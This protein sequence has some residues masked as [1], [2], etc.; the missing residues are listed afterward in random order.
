MSC[1][2]D[3]QTRRAITPERQ[4][5][6]AST[7]ASRRGDDAERQL[8]CSLKAQ[9]TDAVSDFLAIDE[10][11]RRFC[12]P[13]DSATFILRRSRA[14]AEPAEC[15]NVVHACAD[16][17]YVPE[18]LACYLLATCINNCPGPALPRRVRRSPRGRGGGRQH[19]LR[20]RLRAVP[21]R[22]AALRL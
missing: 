2:G 14:L 13:T 21:E 1:L 5:A 6:R 20:L 9:G 8:G 17:E 19:L 11:A 15:Q 12:D 7:A 18:L 10:C 4:F 22:R 16:P 3:Y